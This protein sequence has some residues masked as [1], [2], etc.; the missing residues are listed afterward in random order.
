MSISVRLV[1]HKARI[2]AFNSCNGNAEKPRS[3]EMEILLH[4]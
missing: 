4:G 3:L 2:V 1:A